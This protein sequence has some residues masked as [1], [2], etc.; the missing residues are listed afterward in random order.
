ML[1]EPFGLPDGFPDWPFL[2][3]PLFVLFFIGIPLIR[4]LKRLLR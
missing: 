4:P 3:W 1:R 2:N